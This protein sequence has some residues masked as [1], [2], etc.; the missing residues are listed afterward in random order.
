MTPA[1]AYGHPDFVTDVPVQGPTDPGIRKADCWYAQNVLPQQPACVDCSKG[2]IP[3][4]AM[5]KG[6]GLSESISFGGVGVPGFALLGPGDPLATLS[7]ADQ[8]WVMNALNDLN[9]KIVSANGAPCAT[10]A[11]NLSSMVGCFQGWFNVNVV[12]PS[13]GAAKM[14][15]TDAN[16]DQDTLDA[17][18]MI[19]S[20]DQPSFPSAP[21]A[22]APGI[23]TLP[24][25]GVMATRPATAPEAAPTIEGLPLTIHSTNIHDITAQAV[26]R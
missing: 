26:A 17:I 25:A 1:Q 7:D 15:R 9:T 16:L 18:K 3:M 8:K 23:P 19:V 4:W 20:R 24:A 21:M 12:A 14:L 11:P 2:P 22:N 5:T 6:T 10:W 13:N